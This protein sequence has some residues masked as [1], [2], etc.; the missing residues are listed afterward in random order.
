MQASD[1]SYCRKTQAR[2]A[3]G[4][5]KEGVEDAREIFLTDA[6]TVVR[7]FYDSFLGRVFV[8]V[9]RGAPDS[10]R[11]LAFTFNGLD[12]ID[13]QVEHRVFNLRGVCHEHDVVCWRLEL[14]MHAL[15]A[16]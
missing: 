11:D 15:I 5:R 1:A 4:L 9:V 12:R 14:N 3:L 16:R 10:D 13:D 8:V 2:P 7:D 6:A